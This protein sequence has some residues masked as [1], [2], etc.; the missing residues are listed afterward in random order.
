MTEQARH[1]SR[2]R[3]GE[4]I[5]KRPAPALVIWSYQTP[6][7]RISQQAVVTQA[8]YNRFLLYFTSEGDGKDIQNKASWLHR[9]PQ[10]SVDGTNDALTLAV[11]ATA[12][13]Y[14]ASET[15][16][17]A[18]HRHARNLYGQALRQ[19]GRLLARVK[20]AV[21]AVTIHMISTSVLFSIFEAM[22]ATTAQAYCLHIIGAAKMFEVTDPRQ[23]AEGVLCQLF[24]HLR[25]QMAF[26]TLSEQRTNIN[27]K[28]ILHDS[29]DYED[30]P[31]FQRLT[32]QF[33]LL[34]DAYNSAAQMTDGYGN[35]ATESFMT[36]EEHIAF[37]TEI[38]AL[39]KE[40][41]EK[42]EATWY[43]EA[44][45]RRDFRDIFTALLVAYFSAAHILLALT[46]P[47][48]ARPSSDHLDH[49][50]RILE[51]AEHMQ[52]R[53]IGC[54]YMRIA[55]PLLLVALHATHV[56]QRNAAVANFEAWKKSTMRGMSELALHTINR[57]KQQPEWL[58]PVAKQGLTGMAS[59]GVVS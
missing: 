8:F 37:K 41:N 15:H 56:E 59:D 7:P 58:T 46:T 24:F 33:T 55:A 4:P 18:L 28:K 48:F 36:V 5:V 43:D 35:I 47:R 51:A 1:G 39:W 50:K 49:Y 32:T 11:Q 3:R 42:G 38:D 10:L 57:R 17:P 12:S 22:Q 13:S 44:A 20:A 26:L 27:V 25:T 19:H 29:L 14:C 23:C 53:Q 34:A 16:D 2:K 6:I 54:A 21:C 52:T 40:C 45:H 31:I 9:L 30:L